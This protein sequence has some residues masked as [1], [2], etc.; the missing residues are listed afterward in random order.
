MDEMSKHID[1][2]H[3][4]ESFIT[5]ERKDK[6]NSVLKNRTYHFTVAIEDVYQMHNTS[7][8]MRSC[9]VFGIQDVHVIEQKFAKTIDGEI[10]LGAQKWV[11]VHRYSSSK[12]CLQSLKEKG[13]K[14]IATSPHEGSCTL[15][16]FD[17]SSKSVFCFGTEKEGLSTTILEKADGFLKIP[18]V[19]FSES[20]NISVAAAIIMQQLTQRL[21]SSQI[22]W[23]LTEEEKCKKRLDWTRKSVRDINRVEERWWL[24]R[25]KF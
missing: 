25:N 20:L 18:M 10:A 24:E 14:I 6:F 5:Q 13:Y 22:K 8:V 12:T 2:L 15:D 1:L 7:A 19:G 11:D 3:Y 21:R 23:Q 4:L 16:D 17:I 9:D